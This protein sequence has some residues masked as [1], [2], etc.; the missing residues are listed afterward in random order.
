MKYKSDWKSNSG[1]ENFW[2]EVLVGRTIV[3]LI[4]DSDGLVSMILD[5]GEAIYQDKKH[6]I[7]IKCDVDD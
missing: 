5:N 1:N 6:P 3:D 4:F 2:K 7:Y